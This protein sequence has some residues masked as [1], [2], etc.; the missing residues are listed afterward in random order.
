MI[1]PVIRFRHR[2]VRPDSPAT[3][4]VGGRAAAALSR[5]TRAPARIGP[6][7]LQPHWKSTE[8]SLVATWLTTGAASDA[9]KSA[10]AL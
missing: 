10:H 4:R 8:F 1:R 9:L 5:A 7:N 6:A 2:R 3:R